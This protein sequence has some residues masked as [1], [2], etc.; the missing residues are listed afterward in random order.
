MTQ[1]KIIVE[2]HPDGY[3]AYPLGS[4]DGVVGRGKTSEHALSNVKAA[5]RSQ[6]KGAEEETAS[7][8][9][10]IIEAFVSESGVKVW[11]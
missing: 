7:V 8:A 4:G 2:K 5:L 1:L 6:A 9:P 10:A 11:W 3:I